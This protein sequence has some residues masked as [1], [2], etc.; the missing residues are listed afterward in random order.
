V[1][2]VVTTGLFDTFSVTNAARMAGGNPQESDDSLR[3][4]C[5]DFV[6]TL[7]RGTLAALEY[8]AKTVSGV[9]VASAV[10]PGDGTVSLY[11]SDNSGSSSP[12]MLS[13]VVTEM[14]N[15]RAGGVVLNVLGGAVYS[16]AGGIVLTLTTRP[17]VN[18]AALAANIKSAIISRVNKLK[19]GE[20]LTATML[21]Q[22]ITSVD[23]DG[24]SDVSLSSPVGNVDPGASGLIRVTA[25]E[26]TVS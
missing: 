23:P 6:T 1:V 13:A 21:K 12:T 18:S 26:I 3:Q 20:V 2:R 9:A 19:I 24:I 16:I 11:V 10:E 8:G 4:R 15:W 25:G 5:R 14:L 7:R 22:A 17:G